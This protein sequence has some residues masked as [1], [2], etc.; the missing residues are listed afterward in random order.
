MIHISYVG[1][2]FRPCFNPFPSV[3]P[4]GL[5]LSWAPLCRPIT[6][7]DLLPPSSSVHSTS[8]GEPGGSFSGWHYGQIKRFIRAFWLF[9]LHSPSVGLVLPR[10]AHRSQDGPWPRPHPA[11]GF[12]LF[13]T[14]PAVWAQ[15]NDAIQSSS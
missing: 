3:L 13:T 12:W 14:A 15:G 4:D 11:L 1:K 10:F 6:A 9:L 2:T 8:R 5:S 7:R